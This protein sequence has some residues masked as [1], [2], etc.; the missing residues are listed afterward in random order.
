MIDDKGLLI[1]HFYINVG[2]RTVTILQLIDRH[3]NRL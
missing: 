2:V 1:I 3:E